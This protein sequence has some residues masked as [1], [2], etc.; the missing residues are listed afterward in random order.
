MWLECFLTVILFWT[1]CPSAL[2]RMWILYLSLK[3][4]YLEGGKQMVAGKCFI[5]HPCPM[6]FT[7]VCGIFRMYW[8]STH[9]SMEI[10]F[11][12]LWISS[13]QTSNEVVKVASLALSLSKNFSSLL[14]NK[15]GYEQTLHNRL[16]SYA[17]VLYCLG[18]ISAGLSWGLQA[19]PS[20]TSSIFNKLFECIKCQ[21]NLKFYQITHLEILSN[22]SSKFL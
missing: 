20:A 16:F 6:N 3:S 19:F 14:S 17:W 15:V 5:F 7:A 10:I 12:K 4:L 22:N 18:S 13:K 8:P 11:L 9:L 2:F 1:I 21:K